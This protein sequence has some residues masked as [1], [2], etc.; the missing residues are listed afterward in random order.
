ML[1]QEQGYVQI[2]Y[3]S[4]TLSSDERIKTNIKTI[5]YAL[6]KTLLLH[7]DEYNDIRIDPEKKKIGLVAQEVEF[8][9]PDVV[10]TDLDTTM[11]TI[12]YGPIVALLIEAKQETKINSI[13][14]S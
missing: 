7:S 10:L 14:K 1:L 8:I 5:E 6:D 13:K 4:G 9:I 11:K 2:Q 12:E 3:G